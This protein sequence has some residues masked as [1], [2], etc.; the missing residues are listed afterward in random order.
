MRYVDGYVLPVPKKN[1]RAYRQMAHKAGKIWRKYGALDYFEGVGDDLNPKFAGIKFPQTVR[2]KP[3]E[4]LVFS[5]IAFKSR[6][7]RDRVNAKVMKDPVMNDPAEKD[8]PMPFDMKRM[9]YG[10]FRALVD[11]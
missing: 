1:L 10:G 2:A 6:A 7:H 3:G 4:T 5:F 9:V 8:K 11:V